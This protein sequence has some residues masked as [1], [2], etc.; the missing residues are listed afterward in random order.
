MDILLPGDIVENKRSIKGD[1]DSIA[2]PNTRFRVI[3][4]DGNAGFLIKEN[5]NIPNAEIF[6]INSV[7][8]VRLVAES[9]SLQ[10]ARGIS[11]KIMRST[12]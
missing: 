7:E 5:D 3:A 8:M 12:R 9:E 2:P 6:F 10:V 1:R 11:E 4:T